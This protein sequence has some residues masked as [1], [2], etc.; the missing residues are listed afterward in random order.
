[1]CRIGRTI[2][3]VAALLASPALTHANPRAQAWEAPTVT[4][5]QPHAVTT[6]QPARD[7]WPDVNALPDR[8]AP[9][10]KQFRER[11]ARTRRDLDETRLK[12]ADYLKLIAGNVD[13]FKSHQDERGAIIDPY[14]KA[15]FQYATPC[16]A[17]AAATLVAHAR[18]DDLLEP[19]AK[20]FD[21]ASS[22]LAKSEGA[23][24]HDDFYAPPLARAYPL[25][26]DRVT[27][28]RAK[29]WADDLGG[30]DPY[31]VY[32]Y[33]PG[34]NNW[35]VVAMSGEFLFH[36]LGLRK[37]ITFV[38]D[39]VRAQGRHFNSPWGLYTEGPMAYDHFPRLW[40]ADLIA[41]GYSG[42]R[43]AELTEVLR[44]AA[45]AS[46][47]MQSPTGELP[48][49]GRSAHHQWN[50][51]QQC[52]TYEIFAARALAEDDLRLAGVFKRAAR[53]AL[54][55]MF[56][57]QRPSGEMWIVKNRAD[58]KE[59]HGYESYSSHSQYNLLAVAMLAIAHDHARSS[60]DVPEQITP[61]EVGGFVLHIDGVFHKVFASAGGMYI[62]LDVAADPSHNPT[63]LLRVHKKSFDPQLGP[64][65]GLITKGEVYPDVPRTTA[66]IGAAWKDENGNWKR[67]AEFAGPNISKASVADVQAEP[68]R[69]RFS[70]IYEGSFSGP[71]SAA[72]RYVITPE[73]VELT[74]ELPG[75]DGPTRIMFPVLDDLGDGAKTAI[76]TR[77]KRV[78][79]TLTGH[80]QTFTAPG[81]ASV[82]V[83]PDRYPFRNGWARLGVAEFHAG[84]PAQLV[85]RP[86][87]EKV[88]P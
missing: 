28:A 16:F 57:W 43:A 15:E 83:E 30:F 42:P 80:T 35:N 49:G 2:T 31:K 66:A 68:D 58:P 59:Q 67:L 5:P 45:L 88:A 82:T 21:W 6:S 9:Y 10:V 86:E 81:A 19:A 33:R 78:S 76:A 18:R 56:R 26:K 39:S 52:V 4:R 34:A 47:F 20:A 65:E 84:T 60:E 85:I 3:I 14:R 38:E 54:G 8:I 63:G 87:I 36:K 74:I 46:L 41:S 7:A 24:N 53:L 70:V 11:V 64:S 40:A 22:Q 25:L 75:Y 13:F 69:V 27:P 32:K 48:T 17:Y 50:E 51:A 44:R 71:Q 55:S 79:V 61:A 12:R 62:E 73:Q 72:E 77:D 29:K 37:E 1:M 23:T